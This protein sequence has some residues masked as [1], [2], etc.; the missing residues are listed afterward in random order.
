MRYP[1]YDFYAFADQ[2]DVWDADKIEKTIRPLM[3]VQRPAIYFANARLADGQLAYLGRNVYR[4]KPQTDFYSLVC[5][6]G[7]LGCTIGMNG[8]LAKLIQQAPIPQ[9]MIMHDAFAAAVCAMFDG[10][11]FYDEQAHM[12]YRQHGNNVVGSN[13]TKWDAFKDRISIADQAAS[14]LTCYPQLSDPEK[15]AFLQQV[16]YYRDSPWNALKLSMSRKLHC[17]TKNKEITTRLAIL[18]RNR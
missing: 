8:S 6:G 3:D 11:F 4:R 17:N 16:A 14:L 13:W 15:K 7:I 1:G 10:I 18:L 2:D 5:N 12:D 9:K